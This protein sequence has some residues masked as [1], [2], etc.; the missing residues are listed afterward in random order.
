MRSLLPRGYSTYDL[1]NNT[2]GFGGVSPRRG[3]IRS[4]AARAQASQ[5]EAMKRSAQR[6][7][8][9]ELLVDAMVEIKIPDVDRGKLDSPYH[10]SIVIEV[11]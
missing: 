10:T 8:G 3:R 5:G 1:D 4:E 11:C 6:H 9:R 7:M 2:F